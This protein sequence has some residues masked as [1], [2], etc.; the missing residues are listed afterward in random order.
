MQL[1][2]MG[3]GLRY[4]YGIFR[5][6][7]AGRLAAR[8]ARQLAAPARPLG[9]RRGRRRRSRS[10]SAARSRCTAAV[11]A[12]SPAGRPA[13][14]ACR[15]IARSSATAARRSTR[16]GC[17]PRPRPDVFD[18]QEFSAGDFVGAAGRDARRRVADPRPLSRRL[19]EHGPGAALRA[20]VLPRR[21][22]AGRPRCGASAARNADWQRAARQG[23]HPAQR[24]PPGAGRPRADAHPARRGPPRLGRG[25]GPHPAHARLHQPHAA[26]RGPGEMAGA[27]GSSCCCRATW[28][29]STRSTAASSTRCAAASPA[30]RAASGA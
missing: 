28:R 1:P 7:I 9:G 17:G 6:T 4:E 2:A 30:T 22:L 13:C 29:S 27:T 12:R 16:C 18:F 11:C 21:L 26:A 15:S 8:A 23:R 19:D 3:Y 24:H 14:S 20:G 10:S 25:L 5:Q